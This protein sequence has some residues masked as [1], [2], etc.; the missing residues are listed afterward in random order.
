MST[1]KWLQWCM[2]LTACI[3]YSFF[4]IN[5]LVRP[6]PLSSLT[7][8]RNFHS[9][10]LNL[11]SQEERRRKGSELSLRNHVWMIVIPK[12][13]SHVSFMIIKCLYVL[14]DDDK[15]KFF[16][17]LQI[18]PNTI[19]DFEWWVYENL[20]VLKPC[21]VMKKISIENINLHCNVNVK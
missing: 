6:P 3:F 9:F 10:A 17:F 14:D 15:S 19:S 18:T 20:W 5:L 4:F 7:R 21:N 13:S 2:F 8:F 1:H 12:F 16:S 11:W